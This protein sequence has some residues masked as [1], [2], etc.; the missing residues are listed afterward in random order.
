MRQSNRYLSAWVL[1]AFALL[2]ADLRAQPEHDYL[3]RHWGAESLPSTYLSGVFQRPSG[4]MV[5][6]S[7]VGLIRYDGLRFDLVDS[8][9]FPALPGGEELQITANGI[10]SW[11]VD[12][13]GNLWAGTRRDGV[14]CWCNGRVRQVAADL[15]DSR[16]QTLLFDQQGQLRLG[17]ED[18]GAYRWDGKNFTAEDQPELA[19]I[20][21]SDIAQ[22]RE[23]NL[24]FATQ[25]NGLVRQGGKLGGSNAV[26]NTDNGLIGKNVLS[27]CTDSDLGLW[28]GLDNGLQRLVGETLIDYPELNGTPVRSIHCQDPSQVWLATD[29]GLYRQHHSTS[30]FEHLPVIDGVRLGFLTSVTVDREG[31]L[32]LTSHGEGLYQLRRARVERLAVPQGLDGAPVRAFTEEDDGS[33]LVATNRALYS[34]RQ[35]KAK[36]RPVPLKNR[37]LHDMLRDRGGRLWLASEEGLLRTEPDGSVWFYNRVGGLVDERVR[38]LFESR[39]GTL[40]VASAGGTAMRWDPESPASAQGFRIVEGTQGGELGTVLSFAEDR[41][42]DVLLGTTRGLCRLSE[43]GA[44][45]C[46]GDRDGLPGNMVFNILV[47]EENG[48]LW[49][50]TSGGLGHITRQGEASGLSLVDGLGTDMVLNLFETENG[51]FWLTTPRGILKVRKNALVSRL[52]N[53]TPEKKPSPLQV[54]ILNL[55]D[56]LPKSECTTGRILEAS[57]GKLWFPT[58]GGVAIVDP[59]RVPRNEVP[60]LVTIRSMSVDEKPVS[61]SGEIEVPPG[62]RHVD[63][64]FAAF[65]FADPTSVTARYQLV[66]LDEDWLDAEGRR[67]VH[68]A[69]L[70]P[71][72]YTF[73]VTAANRDGVWNHEG[74][75]VRL[76]VLPHWYQR[77]EVLGFGL[78]SFLGIVVFAARARSRQLQERAARAEEAAAIQREA[79]DAL[80]ASEERFRALFSEASDAIFVM[81]EEGVVDCNHRA[82]RLYGYPRQELIGKQIDELFPEILTDDSGVSRSTVRSFE[83]KQQRKD[84]SVFDSEMNLSTFRLGNKVYIQAIV[85]DASE[86]LRL[87]AELE[88]KR[89]EMEQFVF[90]ISHDLRAPLF[91]IKGF[92]GFLERDVE[93]G[94]K[95]RA[96]ADL[97]QVREAVNNM[98]ETLEELLELS[99]IGR[100][101]NEL[102]RVPLSELA[103]E[104]AANLEG[105]INETRAALTIDPMLPVVRGDRPRLLAVFQNL[106]ENAIK[107]SSTVPK[108]PQIEIGVRRPA[109]ISDDA[110]IFVS[111]NGIGIDPRYHDQVFGLFERLDSESEGT[112]IGLATVKRVIEVHGGRI[113]IESEGDGSGTSFC[114]VLPVEGPPTPGGSE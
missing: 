84:G 24:F 70:D 104:A 105:R 71:G 102:E 47:D 86:R 15:I 81:D 100:V 10:Y 112:G 62:A 40:W 103:Q 25:G 26:W 99:R 29:A 63:F 93:R 12:H 55:A 67:L 13:D 98:G 4:G 19:G 34:V 17:L 87:I 76:R 110:V 30:A 37:L 41:N 108:K 114:F 43:D 79:K 89:Q 69:G 14:L 6:T 32:W 39:D 16:V 31:S 101:I 78:L 74:A 96:A 59:R 92:L 48:A 66:G 18:E 80:L 38:R 45:R 73:R 77:T 35:G 95:E 49:L 46:Q 72:E 75:E 83:F 23:E 68:Y 2:A 106:I 42:G 58:T 97:G 60:P 90:T 21:I 82:E 1:A 54:E 56:G 111:D 57:D 9:I 7:H 53:R 27:L 85:R 50:A 44:I 94:D 65:S 33:V 107:F 61:L 64:D 36:V 22:D 109:T 51:L 3:V 11:A 20:S 5:M 8:R 28:V 91:T 113:W 52:E 88:A